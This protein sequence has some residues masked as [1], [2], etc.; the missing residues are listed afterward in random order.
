MPLLDNEKASMTQELNARLSN[1]TEV[2][3]LPTECTVLAWDWE[4]VYAEAEDGIIYRVGPP[5][6]IT[7]R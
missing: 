1:A 6:V 3:V 7:L 5:K 2:A 4:T